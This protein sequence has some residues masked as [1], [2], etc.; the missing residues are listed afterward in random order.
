VQAQ[1]ANGGKFIKLKGISNDRANPIINSGGFNAGHILL[2]FLFG[3]T[4]LVIIGSPAPLSLAKLSAV[5]SGI[6][7]N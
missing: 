5:D 4:Q 2:D 7:I 3:P 1:P 6:F